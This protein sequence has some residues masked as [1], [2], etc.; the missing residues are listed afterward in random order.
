MK[1]S[2]G[3]VL[4]VSFHAVFDDSAAG[5]AMLKRAFMRKQP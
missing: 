5:R 1:E 3:S 4:S 2:S